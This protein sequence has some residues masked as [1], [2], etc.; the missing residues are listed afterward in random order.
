LYGRAKEESNIDPSMD[1]LRKEIE[2]SFLLNDNKPLVEFDGL[3]RSEMRYLIH[4]PFSNDSP[5]KLNRD[6]SDPQPGTY[7]EAN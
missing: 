2:A 1:N 6:I 5:L 7:F 3:S 4:S